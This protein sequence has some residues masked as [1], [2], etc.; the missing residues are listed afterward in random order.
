MRFISTMD[1]A[2]HNRMQSILKGNDDGKF[3]FAVD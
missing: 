2:A 1:A 3:G